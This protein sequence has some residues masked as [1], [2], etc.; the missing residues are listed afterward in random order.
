MKS[1]I[2]PHV[3]R[4][5]ELL[6]REKKILSAKNPSAAVMAADFGCGELRN[7]DSLPLRET[8]RRVRLNRDFAL[9]P[10]L[11]QTTFVSIIHPKTETSL[12]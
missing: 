11:H 4:A 3:D 8:F 5:F 1:W 9:Q 12:V 6:G 2:S 7:S 10:R